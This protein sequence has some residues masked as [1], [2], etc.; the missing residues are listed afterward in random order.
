M[1]KTARVK[2]RTKP[3]DGDDKVHEEMTFFSAYTSHCFTMKGFISD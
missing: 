1:K 2:R 3:A